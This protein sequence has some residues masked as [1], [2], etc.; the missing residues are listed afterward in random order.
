MPT[1]AAPVADR[2]L[3]DMTDQE[4]QAA[5]DAIDAQI[6]QAATVAGG[7]RQLK[8]EKQA[9]LAEKTRRG[10]FFGMDLNLA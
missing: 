10:M 6:A 4:V 1:N 5:I 3:A 2:A 7:R 8:L 9:L